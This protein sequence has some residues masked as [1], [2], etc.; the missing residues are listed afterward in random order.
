MQSSM[1]ADAE[2]RSPTV[3]A[4]IEGN[5]L[6]LIDDGPERLS[7]LLALIDGAQISLK[8][9]FYMFQSD[10]CGEAVM[11][12][13]LAAL[14]RGVN[15]ALM[16]DCFGSADADRGFFEPFQAAGGQFGMRSEEHTSE[17]Q[18][19]MRISYAVFC[20]KKKK[21]KTKKRQLH[22]L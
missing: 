10:D 16:V 6:R 13:L 4:L 22:E 5:H 15:V 9:Y 3:E 1:S 17:L 2:P 8:F 21:N 19:L 14:A 20:L 7:E 12:R 11:D 18:S